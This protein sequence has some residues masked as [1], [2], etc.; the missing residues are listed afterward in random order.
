M[1]SNM[2]KMFGEKL[3]VSTYVDPAIFLKIEAVRGDVPRSRYVGKILAK[4]LQRTEC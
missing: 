4:A 2:P 3:Q 1:E